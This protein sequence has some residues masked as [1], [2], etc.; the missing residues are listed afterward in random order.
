MSTTILM[1]SVGNIFCHIIVY[2]VVF[3]F[4]LHQL[5]FLVSFPTTP[6]KA[7]L[8]LPNTT[9]FPNSMIRSYVFLDL[10]TFDPIYSSLLHAVLYLLNFLITTFSWFSYSGDLFFLVCYSGFSSSLKFLNFRVLNAQFHRLFL[11]H[12]LYEVFC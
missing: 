4:S 2:S 5:Y 11:T 9:V 7:L 6:L 8:M 12:G 1:K 3:P 10:L